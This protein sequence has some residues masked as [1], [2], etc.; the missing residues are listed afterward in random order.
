MEQTPENSP[1]QQRKKLR[2]HA[3]NDGN[4]KDVESESEPSFHGFLEDTP[5]GTGPSTQL[6]NEGNED[7]EW[8]VKLKTI[9]E[10]LE[11]FKS[12]FP[13]TVRWTRHIDHQ[14]KVIS[15]MCLELSTTL[16][17]ITKVTP[18]I[19][20]ALLKVNVF[21][22]E[23]KCVAEE[24]RMKAVETPRSGT[25]ER[26]ARSLQVSRVLMSRDRSKGRSPSQKRTA[27]GRPSPARV[28][29][30]QE[31]GEARVLDPASM[32]EMEGLTMFFQEVKA[33]T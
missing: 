24:L 16:S 18:T 31:L 11:W 10:K 14:E 28:Q 4:Q 19:R 7:Q 8:S 32:E 29:G 27:S 22:R 33:A 6:Q 17:L 21:K 30:I 5:I 25:P 3:H 13:T 20:A 9:E 15:E 12:T 1:P 2:S 26:R 23:L